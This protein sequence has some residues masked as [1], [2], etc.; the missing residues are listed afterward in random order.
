M[1]TT[2]LTAFDNTLHTT[3]TWLKQLMEE[4]WWEDRHQAYHALRAVLHALRDRLTVDQAA[5]LGAQLPLLVRGIYYEGWHPH[6]K[7]VKDRKLEDFLGHLAPALPSEPQAS[8]E[9]ITRAV[10]ALLARHVTAGE[11]E[12]IRTG[13]PTELRALWP[14]PAAV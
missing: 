10:F 14:A 8:L 3:N 9:R 11:I 12:S 1:S 6:G 2:G 7:P 13:L 4:L 5:A